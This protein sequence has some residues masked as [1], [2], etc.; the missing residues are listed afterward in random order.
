[1]ADGWIISS[2][3]QMHRHRLSGPTKV[4]VLD[5]FKIFGPSPFLV[6]LSCN[7]IEGSSASTLLLSFQ[8]LPRS[9]LYT[10]IFHPSFLSKPANSLNTSWPNRLPVLGPSSETLAPPPS[11]ASVAVMWASPLIQVRHSRYYPL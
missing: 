2:A 3:S 5:Q 8:S 4:P 7:C 10:S 1:V 6:P 11:A 9:V